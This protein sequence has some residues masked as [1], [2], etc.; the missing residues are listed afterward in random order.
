MKI[1][2]FVNQEGNTGNFNSRGIIRVYEKDINHWSV[3]DSFSFDLGQSQ[4]PAIMRE[5]LKTFMKQLSDCNV[6]VGD[7]IIGLAYNVLDRSGIHIWEFKGKPEEFLDIV[8]RKEL[9]MEQ[10]LNDDKKDPFVD[11][12]CQRYY[13]NIKDILLANGDVTSK[14]L[15]FPFLD[16]VTFEEL[17]VVFSHIPP[18]LG[19][20]IDKRGMTMSIEAESIGEVQI[21]IRSFL[22][23]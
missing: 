6:L 12:G 2:V 8:W 10:E 17:H 21:I 9:D 14:K 7:K 22:Q 15:L 11:L 4:S 16:R 20:E 5:N 18:W 1:A 19:P 3:V 13:V 23:E